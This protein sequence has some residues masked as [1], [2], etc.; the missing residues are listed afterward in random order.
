MKQKRFGPKPNVTV[1]GRRHR[2]TVYEVMGWCE[3]T[4]EWV[5]GSGKRE[6]IL[7][8]K[9]FI[10]CQVRGTYGGS[11]GR[12]LAYFHRNSKHSYLRCDATQ[13]TILTLSTV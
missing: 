5:I 7:W 9:R 13:R 6:R 8:K 4:T 2:V 11:Y 3:I 12:P 10:A 1:R